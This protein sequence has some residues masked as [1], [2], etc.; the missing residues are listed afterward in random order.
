MSTFI[1]AKTHSKMESIHSATV[2]LKGRVDALV[3][4]EGD[5]LGYSLENLE[6]AQEFLGKAIDELS[7][8]VTSSDAYG[9]MP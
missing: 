1:N 2:K 9:I 7:S 4:A 6:I 5:G 3:A 8:A